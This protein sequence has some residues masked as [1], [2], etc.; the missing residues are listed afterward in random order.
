MPNCPLLSE[1]PC[2]YVSGSED[3]IQQS[4]TSVL[5][6]ARSRGGLQRCGTVVI[7]NDEIAEFPE[8]FTVDVVSPDESVAVISGPSVVTVNIEDDDG[9]SSMYTYNLYVRKV[10]RLTLFLP[11]SIHTHI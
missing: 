3:F 9:N 5:F 11:L 8:S 6:F 4:A 2:I 1:I 10:W 7:L